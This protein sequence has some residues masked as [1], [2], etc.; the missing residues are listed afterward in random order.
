MP[1]SDQ[2]PQEHGMFS[3]VKK[4][5]RAGVIQGDDISPP[6]EWKKVNLNNKRLD[7]SCLSTALQ[8]PLA[9]IRNTE[10]YV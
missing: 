3:G 2:S 5:P 1:R 9:M 8:R 4:S 7:N 6:R 10:E